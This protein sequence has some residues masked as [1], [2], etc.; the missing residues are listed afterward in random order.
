MSFLSHPGPRWFTIP[1]HRPF[2]A[3]L[4]DGVRQALSE[5]GS[6]A[7]HDAVLLVPTRR[8]ARALAETFAETGGGRAV[9][10]PQI[11]A[12]GDL[13]EDEPPFEA[14][15]TALDLPPAITPHRRRFELARL[16]SEHE[17]LFETRLDAAAALEF[18]GALGAFLDGLQLEEVED[19]ALDRIDGLVEGDL[20]QHWLRS[21][22]FLKIALTAWPAR[23]EELGVMD[24]SARRV[25]LLRAL[26][27]AWTVKPPDGLVIAAGS[28]GTTPANADLLAAIAKA[29]NGAVVLPGLDLELSDEA[30]AEVEEQHPQGAMKRLLLRAKVA[31]AL[32]QPWPSSGG[33][34]DGRWRRRIVNEALRPAERTSDWLE[35]IATLHAEDP[36]AVAKGLDGLAVLPAR[37]E[38]A[39]ADLAAL[40][41]R[42]V[43]VTPGK[44]AALIT[45]DQALARRVSAR[46]SRWGVAADSSS[47]SPLSGHPPGVLAAL[48]ARLAAD[49][50]DPVALLGVL[51][52]P[53]VRLGR[54]PADLRLARDTLERHAL[55]GPRLTD[56]DAVRVRL[57]EASARSEDTARYEAAQALT[58]DVVAALQPALSPF[59]ASHASIC[60]SAE[61]L[62]RTLEAL[63][64][65]EDGVLGDLW[66]GSSGEAMAQVFTALI[67]DSNGLPDTTAA[68]FADLL[69][70]MLDAETVRSAGAAHP[71][72]QILGAIEARLISADRL[73]L[74]GL[75]E[76]VWPR[77][78]P[79]DPFLSRPM[80]EALKLPPPER[81]LGLS[82]H[83]FAQAASASEVFLLHSE[84][85][86]N[87]PA[88]RSRWLWRLETLARGAGVALP[89]RPEARVWAESLDAPAPF[90]PAER[91]RPKPPLAVR[92]TQLSVTRVETWVRDPY[93]TYARYVL[94]LTPLDR[95]DAPVE[96]R[97]RGT[98][99]HA[100]LQR[101]CETHPGE[102]PDDADAILAGLIEEELEAAG[103]PAHA[104]TR[105]RALAQRFAPHFSAYEADRR[106]G[107]PKL[108]IEQSGRLDLLVDGEPFAL[109]AKADR[110]EV[111]GGVAHVLDYKTGSAPTAKQV[112]AGLAPQLTLT[113]AI[114]MRGGFE[115][116]GEVTPGEL[117]Y[118]KVKAGREP[119]EHKIAATAQESPDLAEAA[120]NGLARRVRR[121]RDPESTYEAKAAPQFL[122]DTGD[123]DHLARVWEWHIIGGAEEGG[124]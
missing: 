43:L 60:G 76:G 116:A 71:R 100:A 77:A 61:G 28:T 107:R 11:R 33:K 86:E 67:S 94:G 92:P 14:G 46:L 82:A 26:A 12:I 111:V 103:M 70:R 25:K 35:V 89:G 29:P 38:E 105:E 123:Y 104:M 22:E 120:L 115:A 24:V 80:R 88:V 15:D 63:C 84:R 95:P 30:W 55:R 17:A 54:S 68:G 74:A 1:A 113:A 81:R 64:M 119:L 21:A 8:A 124:A 114:L 101:F 79:T 85:R 49:P 2:L 90:R 87:A 117:A 99:I 16:V 20:A 37:N 40:L 106:F 7:A 122:D 59:T 109:T 3:D 31:R 27:E 118:V 42:E 19:G 93:A 108:L 102:C 10:L 4:A 36:G 52:H 13:D 23:L 32:V 48:A 47:G 9:L 34:T 62:A 72:L 91:P 96:A 69:H 39:C 66:S 65:D 45:P 58:R 44:T 78:A 50:T 98:A 41:L 110:I 6:E 75:E 53:F 97:A 51:K 83:D 73:I 112:K 18:G 57:V 56:W 5:A 121:F